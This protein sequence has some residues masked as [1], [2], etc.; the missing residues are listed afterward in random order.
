MYSL[1]Y[2]FII[3]TENKNGIVTIVDCLIVENV[4]FNMSLISLSP[5]PIPLVMLQQET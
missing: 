4:D 2:L 1:R 5:P 3:W